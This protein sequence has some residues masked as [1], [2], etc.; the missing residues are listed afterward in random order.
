[1]G[2]SPVAYIKL[3]QFL[4]DA[5]ASLHHLEQV[6][7]LLVVRL[8]SSDFFFMLLIELFGEVLFGQIV[9]SRIRWQASRWSESL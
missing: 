5:L 1:M 7:M 3:L 9:R 4:E 2:P 8:Q 6:L